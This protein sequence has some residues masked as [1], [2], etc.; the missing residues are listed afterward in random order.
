VHQSPG[1]PATA[2]I[3]ARL[4]GLEASPSFEL[5][6]MLVR[7]VGLTTMFCSFWGLKQLVPSAKPKLVSP[8][9]TSCSF[10]ASAGYEALF[11]GSKRH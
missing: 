10:A 7:S 4:D 6:T 11:I 8:T 9:T 5:V 2:R 3:R 1:E